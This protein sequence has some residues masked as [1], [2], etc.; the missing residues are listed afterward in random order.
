MMI[1][2]KTLGE[3]DESCYLPIFAHEGED[4]IIGNKFMESTYTVFDMEPS[5][6]QGLPYVQMGFGELNKIN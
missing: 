3:G 6:V 4:W 1:D 2:G 5:M